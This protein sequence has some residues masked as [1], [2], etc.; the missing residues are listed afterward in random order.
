M[1]VLGLLSQV[2]FFIG[3]DNFDTSSWSFDLNTKA[4]SLV[5]LTFSLI[6]TAHQFVGDPIDC[7]VQDVPQPVMDTYCWIHSTFTLP[8]RG[9]T[10]ADFVGEPYAHPG[11]GNEKPGEVVTAH[12]YYQWVCFMLFLQAALF[13]LPRMLWTYL[14]SDTMRKT[15]PAELMYKVSDPRMPW[16]PKPLELISRQDLVEELAAKVS[17]TCRR[18]FGGLGRQQ[19]RRYCLEFLS[20]EVL[21]FVNLVLQMALIDTFVGGMF[22]AYGPMVWEVISQDPETRSDHMNLVFPKVGKCT[23]H[24]AGPSGTVQ[25]FDGMCVLPVNVFNEKIYA[26][27]WF[28]MMFAA[29]VTLFSFLFRLLTWWMACLRSRLILNKSHDHLPKKVVDKLVAGLG[30]GNWFFLCQMSNNLDPRTFVTICQRIEQ[31]LHRDSN[32]AR[33]EES[34]KGSSEETNELE[35]FELE[36]LA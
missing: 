7:V 26:F 20:C 4:T 2:K 36:K 31:D 27:L 16:F 3:F 5:F 34:L 11:V 8:R 1:S 32:S 19:Y 21:A 15:I 29:V 12:K 33:G 14:E 13:Y 9:W 23:F 30:F 35:K 28:W 25:K 10:D 17:S 18:R 24:R 22:M 6:V